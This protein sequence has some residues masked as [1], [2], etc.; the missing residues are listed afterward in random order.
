MLAG[1]ILRAL[2]QYAFRNLRTGELAFGPGVTA[3]VGPNAAG[4]SNLLDACYL[5]AS[6][7]LP[8]GRIRDA[9]R[10]GEEEGFVSARIERRDALLEVHVGL[11]A[12]RKVVRLDGQ[13][14]RRGDVARVA[15]AVRITPQDA[16]LVHGGPSQRRGWLDDLLGRLSARYA[17]LARE[18]GK[19]LEQRNAGLR[20]GAPDALL[21]VFAERLAQ[22][23]DEIG[24][25]RGRAVGR[26]AELAAAA[27]AD[28]ASGAKAFGVRLERSQGD[29]PLREALAARAAEE[30]ARGVTVVGPH[31]DDLALELD[32]RSV[33]LFGSRG[34]ART[35][36]LALRVAELR[37]LEEKHGESP[38]VLLDDF[39]AELDGDRRAYLLDL[40]GRRPQALVSGTE[41][42][43]HAD[44]VLRIA[45]GEVHEDA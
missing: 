15:A 21:D 37:L 35:A 23:G 13:S 8:E 10:W 44:R 40:S 39:S 42:P 18:Y 24:E 16:E 31:R 9:L 2:R 32:G 41:P 20:S 11:A 36:S 28:I 7:D 22:L 45:A 17:A 3:V 43:P 29:A 30:R 25:L 26:A 27:Y 34:E 33:Q 1:V 5:A 12:G 6:A 4:K 19:V 38:I 14:A